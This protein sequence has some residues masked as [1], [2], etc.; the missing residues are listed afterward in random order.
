MT[1]PKPPEGPRKKSCEE[2]LG[3]VEMDVKA[4]RKRVKELERRLEVQDPENRREVD[5][6]GE[7]GARGFV[8]GDEDA[9]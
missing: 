5:G 8:D 9:G 1:K 4:L 3:A 2:R 7:D 6:E